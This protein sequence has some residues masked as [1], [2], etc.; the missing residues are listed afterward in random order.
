MQD[1]IDLIDEITAPDEQIPESVPVSHPEIHIEAPTSQVNIDILENVEA[2]PEA[3]VAILLDTKEPMQTIE[4]TTQIREDSQPEKHNTQKFPI[5][6]DT[7]AADDDD[8]I[9]SVIIVDSQSE[10]PTPN[11]KEI[12]ANVQKINDPSSAETSPV[13][14]PRKK[15]TKKPTVPL[16]QAPFIPIT[17]P[18][19][20]VVSKELA[21]A[22]PYGEIKPNWGSSH[23]NR[24]QTTPSSSPKSPI[25]PINQPP[26]YK[27][28]EPPALLSPRSNNAWAQAYKVLT[29]EQQQGSQHIPQQRKIPQQNV[30]SPEQQLQQQIQQQQMQ[31]LQQQQ[32][33]QPQ[34][35]HQ[36]IPQYEQFNAP[37]EQ[38]RY[39]NPQ[40]PMLNIRGSIEHDPQPLS[41]PKN[42]WKSFA[43]NVV[44]YDDKNDVRKLPP[45]LRRSHQKMSPRGD[46]G[47]GRNSTRN[48]AKNSAKSSAKNSGESSPRA[49]D[50]E[51]AYQQQVELEQEEA[52]QQIPIPKMECDSQWAQIRSV[53][54][55]AE[56]YDDSKNVRHLAPELRR[57]HQ[58]SPVPSQEER[59]TPASPSR[60]PRRQSIPSPP[61]KRVEGTPVEESNVPHHEPPVP[62]MQNTSS[63]PFYKPNSL[64]ANI[65]ANVP[66]DDSKVV[67]K[68]P[69]ELRRSHNKITA[70]QPPPPQSSSKIRRQRA[71]SDATPKNR[72]QRKNEQFQHIQQILQNVQ[73]VEQQRAEES[74]PQPLLSPRAADVWKNLRIKPEIPRPK[75]PVQRTAPIQ[76]PVQVASPTHV[77]VLEPEPEP[78]PVK[79]LEPE[80]HVEVDESRLQ[81]LRKPITDAWAAITPDTLKTPP[82]KEVKKVAPQPIQHQIPVQ[83]VPQLVVQ[84]ELQQT[85]QNQQPVPEQAQPNE[86]VE[87]VSVE[88][89]P[90]EVES[91]TPSIEK[92]TAWSIVGNIQPF[93]DSKEVNKLPPEL[94]RT[95][96]SPKIASSPQ[97]ET[98]EIPKKKKSPRQK[99]PKSPRQQK[100][101]EQPLESEQ[102]MVQE[103]PKEPFVEQQQ[104]QQSPVSP[105]PI[106]SPTTRSVWA[107]IKSDEFFDDSKEYRH[108]PAELKRSHKKPESSS[109]RREKTSPRQKEQEVEVLEYEEPQKPSQ[110]NRKFVEEQTS[111][112]PESIPSPSKF[113]VPSSPWANI[114]INSPYDDSKVPR[115]RRNSYQSP[116]SSP[117][118]HQEQQ[119]NTIRSPRG[120]IP[121]PTPMNQ[122][123]KRQ[124]QQEEA[125]SPKLSALPISGGNAAS[126]SLSPRN[127]PEAWANFDPTRK[128]E[129]KESPKSTPAQQQPNQQEGTNFSIAAAIPTIDISQTQDQKEEQQHDQQQLSPRSLKKNVSSAWANLN[130]ASLSPRSR[131]TFDE[132]QTVTRT[133]NDEESQP[134]KKSFSLDQPT[135]TAL[136]VPRPSMKPE[137]NK[138]DD[139]DISPKVSTMKNTSNDEDFSRATTPEEPEGSP[140]GMQIMLK[141]RRLS[142]P[143]MKSQTFQK[144]SPTAPKKKQQIKTIP[145]SPRSS[146]LAAMPAES[147]ST[148]PEIPQNVL[149][150]FSN[151]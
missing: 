70:E 83:P 19:W 13:R 1:I 146:S 24:R 73:Q 31:Q 47:S 36:Q 3:P 102:P 41:S 54:N 8:S 106:T 69:V 81:Q 5:S 35:I 55:E 82:K 20:G 26:T 151:K 33:M 129:K 23:K 2:V 108:L 58:K 109:P 59:R 25:S 57:T 11:I 143:K 21:Q 38:S 65:D 9:P 111:P 94:R 128:P 95:H 138:V 149:D 125:P 14:K 99:K 121:F 139:S 98:E 50:Y 48:S 133:I 88:D 27:Q 84:E 49:I 74:Q 148:Q 132:T 29:T 40:I 120:R 15:E 43:E 117:K 39:Q 12:A 86:V 97:E 42:L 89:E 66:F 22:Q 72:S 135:E 116:P 60:G 118:V 93:D 71:N 68:T 104:S 96:N 79:Q 137:H 62:T 28:P 61:V 85:V 44:P 123:Q 18:G 124:P 107:N 17:T 10:I 147:I 45:E 52:Q 90:R 127:L 37:V 100:Q 126:G 92:I 144:T 101:E 78:E 46:L 140:H 114:D 16:P 131:T 34:Q 112:V 122:Q 110:T 113:S 145:I 51:E 7:M 105:L 56:P 119:Q 67:R 53:L 134:Q 76:Q 136:K 91:L 32:Q 150:K 64:W 4:S 6:Q 30:L 77:P 87:E 103:E 130:I 141:G 63:S 75:S 115:Y 80:E 142:E